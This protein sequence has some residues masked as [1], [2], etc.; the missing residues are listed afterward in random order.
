MR[1]VKLDGKLVGLA[2]VTEGQVTSLD[3]VEGL[4]EGLTPGE[5]EMT[6]E[7]DPTFE[8][9]EET[10]DVKFVVTRLSSKFTW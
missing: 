9:D 4:Y 3:L 1:P 2:I 5:H 8:L 10:G 6:I 7:L